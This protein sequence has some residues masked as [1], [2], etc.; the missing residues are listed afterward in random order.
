MNTNA[1]PGYYEIE[2]NPVHFFADVAGYKYRI[3]VGDKFQF[4]GIDMSG[5]LTIFRGFN[6]DGPAILKK[7][8]GS[9]FAGRGNQAYVY[10]SYMVGIVKRECGDVGW[11]RI[12]YRIEYSKQTQ[13][14]AKL[15]ALR[16]YK[17]LGGKI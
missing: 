4:L 6:N 16:L 17:E 14:Q 13:K 8:P 10:P 3:Y 1:E 2:E 7:A 5:R 11:F 12:H 9:C 15:E